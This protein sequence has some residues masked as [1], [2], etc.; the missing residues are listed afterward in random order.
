MKHFN[1]ILIPISLVLTVGLVI[2]QQG[3]PSPLPQKTEHFDR[4][5][6]WDGH[7][8]RMRTRVA[9]AKIRQDFGYSPTSHAGGKPGEIGG[10]ITPAAEPAY[11]ATAIPDRTLD[12]PL[13]ASGKLYVPRGPGNTLVGFFNHT[14]INEWRT[15][16]TIAL[17]INGRGDGFH[18]HVEYCTGKWRAGAEF[19]GDIDPKT[20]RKDQR[21]L[22]SDTVHH[23]TLRYD[24]E[25]NQGGGAVRLTLNGEELVV[26]LEP[27]H[28]S[29]GATFDRFGILNVVKSVDTGGEL[30]LDDLEINGAPHPFDADPKW[31]QSN[32]RRSYETHN[33]RPVF[34]FGYSPTN[35]AGGARPGEIGGLH[36]RGDERYPDRLAYYGDRIADLTLRDELFASGK[37]VLRRGVSDSTVLL[38]FFHARDSI[39]KAN[40]QKA[41]IPENFLGVA[42]EGPSR[43]GFFFYPVLGVDQEGEYA[44]AASNK[45][46]PLI[47]PDGKPH[48]WSL[49][50]RPGTAQ[51]T[52]R[53]TV[54][55]DGKTTSLDV[56]ASH[57]SI[58]AKFNRFGFVTAHI[59]GNG[60]EVFFDDLTYT[61]APLMR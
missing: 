43:D 59:D 6:A 54:T 5:P 31:E 27:G 12:T 37:V 10:F 25:A 48:D 19:I 53:I 40:A 46:L 4:D 61:V 14:T 45:D 56:P 49:R 29:D 2:A 7:N 22:P 8:N 9:P 30:W 16:N 18:L 17:R 47:L 11:F 52:G 24:P 1:L 28:K 36:F 26:N 21:L 32:N 35:H 60:Q 23:W 13:T 42:V 33:I 41:Q 20:G 57:A 58:G 44:S 50:Y 39:R 38:G 3:Q 51:G 15:P 34:D 55:F